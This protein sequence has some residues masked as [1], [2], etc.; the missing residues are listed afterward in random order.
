MSHRPRR[1]PANLPLDLTAVLPPV[2]THCCS[3]E[4][5]ISKGSTLQP[6][7]AHAPG[8]DHTSNAEENCSTTGVQQVTGGSNLVVVLTI[9]NRD[10][11]L[12]NDATVWA[13]YVPFDG[14]G[15]TP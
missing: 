9:S 1:F 14:Q 10:T 15:N 11:V 6:T 3:G 5:Q 8:G 2:G 12:F 13:L 4:A 7:K